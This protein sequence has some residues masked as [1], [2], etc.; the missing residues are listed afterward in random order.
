MVNYLATL[1]SKVKER[2]RPVVAEVHGFNHQIASQE[3][4]Q[5]NLDWYNL[6]YPN[7][8]HCKVCHVTRVG[9]FI[10]THLII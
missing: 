2:L 6:V 8:F 9:R 10:L 1:R 5:D 3:D 7:T 4:I